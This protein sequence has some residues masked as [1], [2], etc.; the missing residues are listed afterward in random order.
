MPENTETA[1]QVPEITGDLPASNG[2][3][4]ENGLET[5][6]LA[7]DAPSPESPQ[8]PDGDVSD[9]SVS[10]AQV[11]TPTAAP[12]PITQLRE[13]LQRQNAAQYAQVQAKA[14]DKGLA[15]QLAA[16]KARDLEWANDPLKAL[17]AAGHSQEALL[18]RIANPEA[19]NPD[20]RIDA[21]TTQ[22]AQL[23]AQVEQLKQAS[24]DA[25]A[26]TQQQQVA[27]GIT[28]AVTAGAGEG[29]AYEVLALFASDPT[30]NVPQLVMDTAKALGNVPLAEAMTAIED[31]LITDARRILSA[32][33]F[34]PVPTGTPV[35]TASVE[36]PQQ[37]PNGNVPIT[38]PQTQ[39]FGSELPSMM[40]DPTEAPVSATDDYWEQVQAD[41]HVQG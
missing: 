20:A 25:L 38:V 12:D 36:T 27:A 33:K 17:E 22:L 1:S 8:L 2:F 29:Q 26:Q 9:V 40:S 41:L 7:I 15:E 39:M 14:A 16:Y 3:M 30:T 35:A 5:V 21:T 11:E 23:Q 31:K 4:P 19:P 18:T 13:E 24:A 28:Q 6:Q 34:R 37:A 10:P 32:S